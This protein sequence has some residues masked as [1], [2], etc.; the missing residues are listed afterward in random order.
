MGGAFCQGR[1]DLPFLKD[2]EYG[3]NNQGKTHQVV[4]AQFLL[5]VQHGKAAEDHQGNYFLD[6]FQLVGIEDTM[7]DAV[8][9][10]LEAILEKSDAPTDQDNQE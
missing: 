3:Q 1:N 2:E 5:Q 10:N 9:G 6:C 4:P 7:T 8:G